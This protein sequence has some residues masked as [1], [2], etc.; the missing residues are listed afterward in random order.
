MHRTYDCTVISVSTKD[1][2]HC[3]TYGIQWIEVFESSTRR[4]SL[5][6]RG[7]SQYVYRRPHLSYPNYT[8]V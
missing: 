5:P 3:G 6:F 2:Q 7:Y 8:Y 1:R 4:D